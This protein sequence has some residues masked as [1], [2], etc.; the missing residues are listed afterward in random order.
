MVSLGQIKICVYGFPTLPRFLSR[1]NHFIVQ[2]E[3][4]IVNF[5]KKNGE[6]VVQISKL[7]LKHI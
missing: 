4:N 5:I 1:P 2:S 6:N 7:Y 3:Q